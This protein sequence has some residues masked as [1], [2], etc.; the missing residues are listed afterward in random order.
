MALEYVIIVSVISVLGTVAGLMFGTKNLWRNQRAQD[1][2]EI[3]QLA[4]VVAKLDHI[5]DGICSVKHD[6]NDIKTDIKEQRERIVR[7]EE[8]TKQAHRRL[9][10]L[11]G[12]KRG[13]LS[14]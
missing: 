8:S 13:E 4:R 9:D 7:V 11:A 3:G 1:K 5:D 6:M 14:G 2:E 10:E 12:R